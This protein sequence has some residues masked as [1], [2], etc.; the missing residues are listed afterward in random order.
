MICVPFARRSISRSSSYLRRRVCVINQRPQIFIGSFR[1]VSCAKYPC[2][3]G[4]RND[5]R[6]LA[7]TR[8][9]PFYLGYI[10]KLLT[11]GRYYTDIGSELKIIIVYNIISWL[12]MI[13]WIS[14]YNS[15]DNAWNIVKYDKYYNCTSL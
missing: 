15:Y 12:V 4:F 14:R 1:F 9:P 8:R 10:I 5:L 11:I 7:M 2:R 13:L 3:C 6:A